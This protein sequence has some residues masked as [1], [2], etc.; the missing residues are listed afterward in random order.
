[1]YFI[2]KDLSSQNPEIHY[3]CTSIIRPKI[4]TDPRHI[5]ISIL[6]LCANHALYQDHCYLSKKIQRSL[7]GPT[8]GATFPTDTTWFAKITE[9]RSSRSGDNSDTKR[10]GVSLGPGERCLPG[11]W[12]WWGGGSVCPFF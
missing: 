11:R 3:R 10:A 4:N 2:T 9:N 12:R 7:Q 8:P 6:S 5:M 1:M